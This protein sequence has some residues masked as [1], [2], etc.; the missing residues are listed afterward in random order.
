MISSWPA[1]LALAD[2][3]GPHLD[4]DLRRFTD[5]LATSSRTEWGDAETP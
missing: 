2:L 1:T 5:L 4:R 3:D